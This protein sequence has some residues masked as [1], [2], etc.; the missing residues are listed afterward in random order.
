V[1]KLVTRLFATAAIWTQIQTS[2]LKIRK[3]NI[4]K[5]WPTHS[6]P[7]KQYKKLRRLNSKSMCF[8][9]FNVF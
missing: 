9:C 7:P 4:S 3:G 5:G 2:L 8:N 1:A 6:C